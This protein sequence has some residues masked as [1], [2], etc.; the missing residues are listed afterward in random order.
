MKIVFAYNGFESIGIE[1]LS[2]TLKNSGHGVELVY[3]PA[4][5]NTFHAKNARLSKM[6]DNF[7]FVVKEIIESAPDI[8]AFSVVSD[9]YMWACRVAAAVKKKK[10]IPV[11][12]GGVH[13]TC[14]P[15][16]VISHPFVDYLC[17]GEGE[18][19]MLEL[20]EALADNKPVY[21]IANIWTKTPEG[22]IVSNAPRELI[23][24]IDALPMPDK[25]L[26]HRKYKGFANPIYMIMT[27]RG[28][29]YVCSYCYGGYFRQLYAGKG[30]YV[31]RRSTDN[32]LRELAIAKEK[33]RMK[34]VLFVD[35]VFTTDLG[36][37]RLFLR[38][39]KKEINLPFGCLMF[40]DLGEQKKEIISLLEDSGCTCVGMGIQSISERQ[41]KE[42]L[43]RPGSNKEITE[44]I[45]HF[46]KTSMFLYADIILGIPLQ[47]EQKLIDTALFFND[48][49][50]DAV[51][52]MWLR[53]YPRAKIGEIA[54]EKKAISP[55]RLK[56]CHESFMYSPIAQHGSTFDREMGK[57][58]SLL[59]VSHVL[60][61]KMLE[62]I[63]RKRMYK[64]FPSYNLHYFTTIASIFFR[65]VFRNKNGALY[66][67]FTDRVR[68]YLFFGR[69]TLDRILL[70]KIGR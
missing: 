19:A 6:F 13:P 18:Q 12:F 2:S 10:N 41:R 35:D 28:C 47:D 52:T 62:V 3:D 37:L 58:G 26:F 39:Y 43:L 8:L 4:L 33:Y 17:V 61:R 31:R 60:P 24:G 50:P 57:L 49:R 53:Y 32:V 65:R 7:D 51:A 9:D 27:G 5:F 54:V 59:L 14:S 11:I 64:F 44:I 40:P 30:S 69:K 63:L 68:Y 48:N 46:R 22:K 67:C 66:F 56:K 42:I 1:Y 29:P 21:D 25:D 55:E 70:R 45:Q 36:W 16:E 20:V 23:Q 38:N 15:Q 34:R